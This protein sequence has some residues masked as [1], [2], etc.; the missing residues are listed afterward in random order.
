MKIKELIEKLN[1]F[2]PDDEVS[3][4][5]SGYYYD[6]TSSFFSATYSDLYCYENL[7][8]LRLEGDQ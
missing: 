6:G 3:F 2:K 5:V 7:V 8:M 4:E 1:K